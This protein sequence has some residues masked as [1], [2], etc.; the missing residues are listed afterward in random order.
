[1]DI[2]SEIEEEHIVESSNDDDVEDENYRI[3]PKAARELS[4]M[5]MRMKIWM[6]PMRFRMSYGGK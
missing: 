4:L 6:M 2:E 5:M 3:S 1:M